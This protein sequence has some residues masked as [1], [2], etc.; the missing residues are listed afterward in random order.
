MKITSPAFKHNQIIPE[1][2]TCDGLSVNPPLIF[3]DIPAHAITLAL[4]MDDP[5][6]LEGVYDHWILWN[7]K[8]TAKG[9]EEDEKLLDVRRGLNS[10][11]NTGYVG[12]CPPPE[13]DA[14]RYFFRLYALNKELDADPETTSKAGLLRLIEEHLIESAE[15]IGLYKKRDK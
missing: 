9:I 4:I 12:P 2:Y 3:H 1:K 13:D 5:D 7:I 15:L 10:Q 6:A 14:H 8:S 11:G